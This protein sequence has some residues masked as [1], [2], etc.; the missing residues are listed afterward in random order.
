M[1]RRTPGRQ[2]LSRPRVRTTCGQHPTVVVLPWDLG[3]TRPHCAR[4]A[5]GNR[6]RWIVALATLI[7]LVWANSPVSGSYLTLLATEIGPE[8]LHLNLTVALGKSGLLAIFLFVAD[9]ELKREFVAG[10]LRE[11]KWAVVPVAA[12]I[13]GMIV[14]AVLSFA[15]AVLAVI[16]THLPV[17]LRT[18]LLALAVLDDLLAITTI[19]LF[20]TRRPATGLATGRAVAIGFSPCWCNAGCMPGGPC[21]RWYEPGGI[22]TTRPGC[23]RPSR[24]SCSASRRRVRARRSP[25]KDDDPS[26]VAKHFPGVKRD[27]AH[28]SSS[29]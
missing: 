16:Y 27:F 29:L 22:C 1:A 25:G 10:D 12:A 28:R 13:G 19:A 21:C 7:A 14:P 26:S 3:G 18:L 2:F 6:G 23:T 11:L 8:S 9:L 4:A 24:A 15:D 17:A 5:K 20:Y